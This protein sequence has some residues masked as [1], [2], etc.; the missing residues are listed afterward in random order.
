MTLGVAGS[1]ASPA[2]T[3]SQVHPETTPARWM[4]HPHPGPPDGRSPAANLDSGTAVGVRQT[5]IPRS[6]TA[7]CAP[8]EADPPSGMAVG[9]SPEVNPDSGMAVSVSQEVNPDSGM[10]V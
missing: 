1:G 10:A 9:V 4:Y 6:G 5:T 2:G 8:L 7:A 3:V